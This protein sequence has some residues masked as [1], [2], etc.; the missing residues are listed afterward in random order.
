MVGML[1]MHA[2][3]SG[4]ADRVLDGLL[5][6]SLGHIQIHRDGYRARGGAT[7]TVHDADLVLAAAR[8]TP[9]VVGATGRIYGL[10]HASIV[11]GDDN[12]VRRGGGRDVASPVMSLL[13]FEPAQEGQVTDLP[14][15]ITEGRWFEGEAELVVGAGLAERH[16]IQIGDALLPTAIDMNGAM[17][18]PWAV[19]DNVPRVVGILRSGVES[20]DDR[21]AF[22]PR[23]YLAKLLRIEDQVHEIAIR[24]DDPER[25]AELTLALRSAVAEARST[26]AVVA[27]PASRS[28]V[29]V[30][31]A[32]GAGLGVGD[33][34][35]SDGGP[36]SAPVQARL[37]GVEPR[38]ASREAVE[39]LSGRYLARAEDLVLSRAVASAL[40]VE[41]DERIAVMVPLDCGEEVPATACPPAAESFTVAGIVDDVSLFGGQFALVSDQ[42]LRGNIEALA[43][44]VVSDLGEAERDAVMALTARLHGSAALVDEILPWTELAP[45]LHQ[46]MAVF[47]VMPVIMFVIIFFAV[48]LGIVNTMLM[49]TFER[50]RE[51]GL[52]RAL[53]LRPGKVVSMVMW[54]STLLALVGVALGLAAGMPLLWYWEA[55]G[56]NMGALMTEEQSF[57]FA[58]ITIDPTLWPSVGLGDITRAVMTIGLMTAASGLWPALRAARLQP[59]EA[60]RHE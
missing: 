2:M 60:L 59:T 51:L 32:E 27:V 31:E 42:V 35:A 50:T 52:M 58:G 28:L 23:A 38:G 14:T 34:A 7:R 1:T 36:R 16:D 20:Y 3:V 21:M 8:A 33:Q 22:M 37:V 57:D 40:S 49:A 11:R 17:R 41:V 29:I 26:G 47:D 48:A 24:A 6:S 9:G 54:E 13:G 30:P 53:G 25:L 46:M 45:E 19:S 18:G 12:A 15:K 10:S 43:P 4:M 39:E 44:E 5:G 55:N 56:M